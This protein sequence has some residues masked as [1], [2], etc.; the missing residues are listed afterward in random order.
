MDGYLTDKYTVGTVEEIYK[1][2]LCLKKKDPVYWIRRT[3]TIVDE[4]NIEYK[5]FENSYL[6]L[7][8]RCDG[9]YL[10]TFGPDFPKSI[11]DTQIIVSAE[12]EMSAFLDYVGTQANPKISLQQRLKKQK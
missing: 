12:T 8:K 4:N 2:M 11:R 7:E 9:K 1:V 10:L 6:T 3:S 5:L